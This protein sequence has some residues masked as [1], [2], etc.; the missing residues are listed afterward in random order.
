MHESVHVHVYVCTASSSTSAGDM[1]AEENRSFSLWRVNVSQ[2]AV[3]K[4]SHVYTG[5]G[6]AQYKMDYRPIF[7]FVTRGV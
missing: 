1:K 6:R 5:V 4:L 2:D 7:V 3:G